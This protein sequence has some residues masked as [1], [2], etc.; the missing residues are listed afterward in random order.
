MRDPRCIPQSI[1]LNHPQRHEKYCHPTALA[2]MAGACGAGCRARPVRFNVH[3]RSIDR[4]VSL[5]IANSQDHH[6]AMKQSRVFPGQETADI[7]VK[8]T[9]DLKRQLAAVALSFGLAPAAYARSLIVTHLAKINKAGDT[10]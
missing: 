1:A 5:P 3:P 2:L 4:G 8:L 7:N 9:K 6:Q 10:A